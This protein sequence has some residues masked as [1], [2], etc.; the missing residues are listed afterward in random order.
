MSGGMPLPP[1][2]PDAMVRRP[3]PRTMAPLR[4]ASPTTPNGPIT[5]PVTAGTAPAAAT[6]AADDPTHGAG[7]KDGLIPSPHE[8]SVQLGPLKFNAYGAILATGGIVGGVVATKALR[9]SGVSTNGLGKVLVPA[10]VAGLVGARLY[11]VATDWDRYKDNPGDIVKVWNG[12]LG[13]YGGVTAGLAVGAIMAHRAKLPIAPLLDA[14]AL[15][16]PVAQAIGRFGNYT[17]QELYGKPTDL[18][19][20]LQID[21]A[22]RPEG[23]KDRN[24][25]HPTFAYEAI[26]NVALA[27]GLFA[28]SKTWA[29]RPPGILLPLYLAGYGAIRFGVESL[30]IDES[31]TAGGLRTNQWTSLAATGAGLLGAGVMLA[32]AR[33]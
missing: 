12:G 24:S 27:G 32:K 5:V 19:W 6:T 8:G 30:R 14:A 25:F 15:A 29:G 31:H 7:R 1:A 20:G 22:H 33:G 13:I 26:G 21:E 3:A 16:L 10:V 11:H 4:P 23:F 18:P 28:L 2:P 17:N 9:A